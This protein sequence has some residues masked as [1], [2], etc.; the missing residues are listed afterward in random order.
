MT[1]ILIELSEDMARVAEAHARARNESMSQYVERVLR[2]TTSA[3]DDLN[4]VIRKI[5]ALGPHTQGIRA[6]TKKLVDL[7]VSE[8]ASL[9]DWREFDARWDAFEAEQKSIARIGETHLAPHA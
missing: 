5:K 6:P 7:P 1:T 9:E 3:D 2:E 4:N 8:T